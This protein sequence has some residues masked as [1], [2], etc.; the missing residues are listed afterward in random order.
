MI[1]LQ[2]VI[3]HYGKRSLFW[4]LI[5]FAY[6]SFTMVRGQ[7]I[8]FNRCE[9]IK[10]LNIANIH[11]LHV[12]RKRIFIFNNKIF[13]LCF[14][15]VYSFCNTTFFHSGYVIKPQEPSWAIYGAPPFA[16]NPNYTSLKSVLYSN[17]FWVKPL[18]SH[19]ICW[20]FQWPVVVCNCLTLLLTCWIQTINF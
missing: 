14:F 16:S 13:F 8:G 17:M 7:K 1:L 20:K 3:L 18:W 6:L 12:W 10:F 9:C 4:S 15:S 11:V 2:K 19:F 5:I